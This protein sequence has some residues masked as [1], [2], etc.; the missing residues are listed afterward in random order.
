MGMLSELFSMFLHLDQV[1]ADVIRQY[2]TLTYAF[3]FLVIFFETGLVVTPFLPG[4]SLLFAAGA[5]SVT[6]DLN[7]LLLFALLAPAAVLGDAVNYSIGHKI[8][9][10]AFDGSIKILKKEYL[11]KTH[12]FYEKHGNKTIVLARFVPIVRTFAPFVA[13]VGKMTYLQFATYNVIGGVVW[14]AL[15]IAAG[16]FFG[17]IPFVKEN[18]EFVVIGII[19]VSVLPGVFEWWKARQEAKTTMPA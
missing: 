1:L 10:R 13:G 3:L 6:T 15:F 11:D 5:L 14:V 12:A 9:A 16:Y 8:G 7:P 4:D 17:E 2:G 18:F 19:L